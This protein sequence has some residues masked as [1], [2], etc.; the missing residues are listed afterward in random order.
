MGQLLIVDFS[1]LK[2][3]AHREAVDQRR[4]TL[5]AAERERL[6]AGEGNPLEGAEWP[7]LDPPAAMLGQMLLALFGL[8]CLALAWLVL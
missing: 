3:A 5:R 4:E 6:M 1:A 8:I 2:D 7:H